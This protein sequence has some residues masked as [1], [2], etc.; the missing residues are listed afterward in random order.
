MPALIGDS[1][2][3]GFM[4]RQFLAPGRLAADL[5]ELPIKATTMRRTL[6]FLSRKGGYVPPALR[7]LI[8]RLR[9]N[10]EVAYS[11]TTKRT[12]KRRHARA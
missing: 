4:P 10:R 12:A 1:D 2:L 8:E 6:S 9:Q 3:M 11:P 7:L 5:I